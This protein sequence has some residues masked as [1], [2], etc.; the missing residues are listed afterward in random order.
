M[1]EQQI[2][3]FFV[4]KSLNEEEQKYLHYHLKRLSFTISLVENFIKNHET[5]NVLDIGPHFLTYCLTQ[6]LKSNIKVSTLGFANERLC[7]GKF[8]DHHYEID[9]NESNS[10]SLSSAHG[11]FDLI[12]FSET[13]EH[14]YTSPKI[15]LSF[16]SA[17]LK[18]ERGAGIIIQTPNAVSLQK[19]IKMLFGRNP[20]ELIREDKTNPGHYREYTMKE[21]EQYA[22][23]AGFEIQYK[24]YCSYWTGNSFIKKVINLVPSLREGITIL[25]VRK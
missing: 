9:L 22:S 3:D 21:L 5:Q 24:K 2:L 16:L 4:N 1:N 14:L 12:V 10:S 18:K 25:L 17:L 20:Y 8:I 23:E 19:R 7:P 6:S 13:I 15:I 11:K